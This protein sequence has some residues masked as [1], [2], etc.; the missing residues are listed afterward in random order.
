MAGIDRATEQLEAQMG[1]PGAGR[2]EGRCGPGGRDRPV[3]QAN[4]PLRQARRGAARAVLVSVLEERWEDE[5][6]VCGKGE[7][8]G[9]N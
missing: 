9:G 2:A 7:A 6:Q 4:V 3:R 1:S 5:E 8:G